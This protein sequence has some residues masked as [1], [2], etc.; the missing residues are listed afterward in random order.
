MSSDFNFTVASWCPGNVRVKPP[1]KTQWGGGGRFCPPHY[2]CSPLRILRISYCPADIPMMIMLIVIAYFTLRK[3]KCDNFQ[4]VFCPLVFFSKIV[5]NRKVT[6]PRLLILR[7]VRSDKNHYLKNR[8]VLFISYKQLNLSVKDSIPAG[9]WDSQSVY[10][11]RFEPLYILNLKN[12][13][14]PRCISRIP[15]FSST[16]GLNFFKTS[17]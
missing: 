13:L 3:N 15:V 5:V 12:T 2:Y 6:V 9:K 8:V 17:R 14:S 11:S 10:F 1:F 16:L 7:S 4:Q